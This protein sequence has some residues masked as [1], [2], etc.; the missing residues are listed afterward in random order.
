MKSRYFMV[1]LI[2][3]VFFVISFLT[4]ILGPLIPD[5]IQSFHDWLRLRFGMIFLYLTLAYIFS[6]GI[7]AKPLVRNK[8]IG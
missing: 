4:N 8:T 2:M 7:W 6:I 3:L 1:G 5:I